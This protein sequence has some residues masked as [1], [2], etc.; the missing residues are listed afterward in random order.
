MKQKL[1]YIN[2]SSHIHKL[3]PVFKILYLI[4]FIVISFLPHN[5]DYIILASFIL[6]TYLIISS[7]VPLKYYL[8]VIYKFFLIIIA[9]FIILAS[10]SFTLIASIMI[11][12]KFVF[13][14]CLYSMLIYTTKPFD[15]ALG[16]YSF[17]KYFN[18]L[19][20]NKN[21]LF[22]KVYNLVSF[23]Q[24]YEKLEETII[25][26]LERKGTDIRHQNIINRFFTHLNLIPD[27]LSKRKV[28][29]K[30]REKMMFK[31]NVNIENYTS[32]VSVSGFIYLSAFILLIAIYL[33][34]VV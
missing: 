28:L 1:E 6:V 33:M 7:K 18:F 34:K 16:I 2:I 22:L 13:A 32:K 4:L 21:L 10:N 25:E 8:Q 24:D 30:K 20:I 29:V 5:L 26:G 27:V 12:L 31:K 17:I 9:L 15:L 3:S 19:G 23:R 11:V 14:L